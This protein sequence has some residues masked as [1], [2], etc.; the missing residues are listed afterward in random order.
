MSQQ[1]CME[2]TFF[3]TRFS[4]Q[5][6]FQCLMCF[7]FLISVQSKASSERNRTIKQ[8]IFLN[9]NKLDTYKLFLYGYAIDIEIDNSYKNGF[10]II[11]ITCLRPR[12]ERADVCKPLPL[13]H[14]CLM[15][16]LSSTFYIVCIWNL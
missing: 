10:N 2:Y 12:C 8:V 13:L 4:Y 5:L 14:R 6:L 3:K 1:H 15:V 7:V 16:T 11:G 9:R